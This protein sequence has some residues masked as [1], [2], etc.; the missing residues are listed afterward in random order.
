VTTTDELFEY[1]N[2]QSSV[3]PVAV[4]ETLLY[5]QALYQGYES[6]K[7]HPLNITT[8]CNICTTIRGVHTQIRKLPGTTL[9]NDI[10]RKKVYAPPEEELLRSLLTNWQN[11][12]HQKDGVDPL[13]KVAIKHY[14]FEAIHPFSD[15]NG[16][17]GRIINLLYLIE[18]NLLDTPI[19]Y[20]SRYIIKNKAKYYENL[21]R[22]ISEGIWSE[23]ILFFL[24]AIAE[25]S[26]WTVNKIFNI[27]ELMKISRNFI[28]DKAPAIYTKE[29]VE[30]LF[31]QP[32]IR[33]HNLVDTNLI[34]R[35]T[36]SKYLKIL[37][38]IGFLEEVRRG[39]H[40]LFI[41]HQFLRLLKQD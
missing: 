13:I 20:L 23:W 3:L 36:A 40:K 28:K 37:C 30:L 31:V 24:K 32:Y 27:K 10:T 7:R 21:L 39:R 15:G 18:Q 6:L 26:R 41:N 29:L 19:L 34:E 2:E 25:T 16:R 17:T 33:I 12:L 1:A 22:V 14:Q 35:Q 11:Y 38:D 4:K 9:M 5:R 8:A